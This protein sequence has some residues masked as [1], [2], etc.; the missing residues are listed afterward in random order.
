MGYWTN[1]GL[2]VLGYLVIT[3]KK[4]KT[5]YGE[6][7]C[8]ASMLTMTSNTLTPVTQHR[9]SFPQWMY[10]IWSPAFWSLHWVTELK[11]GDELDT[12]TVSPLLILAAYNLTG[13]HAYW[14]FLSACSMLR[15][16][17]KLFFVK[18]ALPPS[19]PKPSLKRTLD[20]LPQQS[21]YPSLTHSKFPNT[22]NADS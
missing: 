10:S 4:L 7:F 22:E 2:L 3:I 15:T 17:W 6:V 21:H 18:P 20:L 12:Y 11:T 14:F 8:W 19:G 5:G 9:E 13:S 1:S 16:M